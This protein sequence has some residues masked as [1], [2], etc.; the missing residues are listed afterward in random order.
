MTKDSG[1]EKES[2]RISGIPLI[3]RVLPP[4][5]LQK[6][7]SQL[8]DPKDLNTVMLVCKTWNKVGEAPS[9]WSQVKIRKQRQLTIKRFQR[10][11]EIAFGNPWSRNKKGNAIVCWPKLCREVLQ[12][13]RLKKITLR[14]SDR[15][16]GTFTDNTWDM[17]DADLFTQVFAKMEEIE[18]HPAVEMFSIAEAAVLDCVIDTILDR[19][20]NLKKLVMKHYPWTV[21]SSRFVAALNKIEILEVKLKSKDCNLL[22]K[23]MMTEDSCLTSLS[24]LSNLDLSE[25]EPKYLFGVFDKLREFGA[26]SYP[27]LPPPRSPGRGFPF[28]CGRHIPFRRDPPSEL[29]YL[30]RTLCEKIASGT[31][32]KKLRLRGLNE[33]LS[34]VNWTTLSKMAT[35][36]E[37]L[38]LRTLENKSPCSWEGD[39][40][41]MDSGLCKACR[42][43]SLMK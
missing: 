19:P 28:P 14:P 5:M 39:C 38:E 9:L 3:N 27:F 8:S 1:K 31:N 7:F 2:D 21:D 29:V 10:C 23:A 13:P 22:F 12:H 36:L 34:C 41:Y 20:N 17:L 4:E 26:T 43:V 18:I 37:K 40:N 16:W 11:E 30:I 35:K 42:L 32:L 15:T 33:E 24:L 6:I 25:C